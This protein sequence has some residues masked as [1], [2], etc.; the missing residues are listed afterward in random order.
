MT[1]AD[2]VDIL[3]MLEH[4]SVDVWI[5][6]GW[7]ID[8]LLGRQTRTHDDLDLVIARDDLHRAA[9][10]LPAFAHDPTADP[11]LPARFVVCDAR[12]RQIDFHPVVFDERGGWQDL[13]DGTR[14]L[15]PASDLGAVGTIAGRQVRCIS[16]ELQLQHHRG[17]EWTEKD[18]HDARAL[19]AELGVGD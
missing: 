10:A 12:G 9:A 1:A 7:G 3:R 17:Y 13:G 6:G 8:A 5:D 2:V 15:Y 4:A 18:E 11:G 14:G 19:V 16:A